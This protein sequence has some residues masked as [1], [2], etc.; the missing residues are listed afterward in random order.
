MRRHLLLPTLALSLSV[1]SAHADPF[2]PSKADQ[3]KLGQQAA[4]DIRKKERVLPDGDA[5]VKLLRRVAN[6]ILAKM[7]DQGDPWT[8]S[9]DVIESKE[10]NAFALPGGPVFFYTGLI[11]KLETED[12]L[13]GVLAHELAHVRKQHWANQYAS[14]MKRQLVLGAILIGTK[15]NSTTQNLVGLGDDL[16]FLKYSRDH[17]TQADD[18]GMQWMTQAGYNPNG[19]ADVFRILSKNAKGSGGPEFLRSHPVDKNRIARIEK[20]IAKLGTTFPAQKPLP[21]RKVA[22]NQSTSIVAMRD[23]VW[24]LDCEDDH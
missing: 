23:T 10:L 3:V 17:E 12:Q 20:S 1:V 22:S 9:F 11:S 21:D 5:R 14:A 6:R 13:A 4:K 18:S 2:R 15:A 24:G 16:L 8:Y 7:D 19:M